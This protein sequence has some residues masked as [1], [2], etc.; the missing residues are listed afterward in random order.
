MEHLSKYRE[1]GSHGECTELIRGVLAKDG[2][3]DE[4]ELL[5]KERLFREIF[6]TTAAVIPNAEYK[7]T[8]HKRHHFWEHHSHRKDTGENYEDM[9]LHK[10]DSGLPPVS[11][12]PTPEDQPKPQPVTKPVSESAAPA[13]RR[14]VYRSYL[15]RERTGERIPLNK[16]IYCVGRKGKTAAGGKPPADYAFET[17]DKGISRRHALFFGRG[18]R[19]YVV[20]IGARNETYVNGK[21]LPHRQEETL[22]RGDGQVPEAHPL[23]HGDK[24]MLRTEVFIFLVEGPFEV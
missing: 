1:D 24:I 13:S 21:G 11:P 10:G 8:E 19:I 23:N 15:I 6:S 14:M 5:E 4:Q 17:E 7:H 2:D 9:T 3:L 12:Q 16:P 20:D 22:Y 18:R